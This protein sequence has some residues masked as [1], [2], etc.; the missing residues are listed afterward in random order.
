MGFGN[1]SDNMLPTTFF[2]MKGLAKGST[3]IYFEGKTKVGDSYEEISSRPSKLFGHLTEVS[4]KE[5]E[6]E[7]KTHIL[8][9]GFSSLMINIINTIAGNADPIDKIELGVYISK[10]GYPSVSITINNGT[11]E[12]N[13]WKFDYTKKLKPLIEETKNKKGEIVSWDKSDLE[14]F[15]EKEISS[16]GFQDKIAGVAPKAEAQAPL[17]TVVDMDGPDQEVQDLPF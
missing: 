10:K 17:K 6:W 13:N 5:F 12:D 7:N 15:L 11:W 1:D 3:E 2:K 14:A 9:G 16:K 8:E 4:V